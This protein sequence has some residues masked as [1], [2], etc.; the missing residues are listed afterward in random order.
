[1]SMNR[2]EAE[3]TDRNAK[4]TR[5]WRIRVFEPAFTASARCKGA[6]VWGAAVVAR[7]EASPY[8]RSRIEV[9][10]DDLLMTY[11]PSP[12]SGRR[13][14]RSF[15]R[16]WR[17]AS[18]ALSAVVCVLALAL[19]VWAAPASGYRAVAQ[20][21]LAGPVVT[22]AAQLWADK[23]VAWQTGAHTHWLKLS[24][25]VKFTVGVYGFEADNAVVRIVSQVTPGRTIQHMALYLDQARPLPGQTRVAASAPR[26]LVTVSTAGK[27]DLTTN[28]L[29]EAKS[30]PSDELV[31]A[32]EARMARHD[33]A[34][35][36]PL[37]SAPSRP[38]Y[39]KQVQVLRRHRREAIAQSQKRQGIE[40]KSQAA[41]I[42]SRAQ[43]A[44]TGGESAGQGKRPLPPILPVKGAVHFGFDRI[45]VQRDKKQ[46]D[47]M[48]IGHVR[49]IYED[50]QA[51]RSVSLKADK[52]VIFLKG[53]GD[54]GLAG[55]KVKAS[56]V[57][58]VYLED[59]AVAS[60]GQYTLRAPRIYYDVAG[61]RAVLLD[62]VL[63]T[64]DLT[65]R[66]PLYMRANIIRQESATSF[67]AQDAT[68]TNSGFAQPF[69]ALHAGRLSVSQTTDSS[70]KSYQRFSA[71]DTTIRMKGVPLLYFP[72]VSGTNAASPMR[73]VAVG[74]DQH[75]GAQVKT[76]WDIFSLLGIHSPQGTDLTG[77]LDYRGVHGPAIGANLR[78]HRPQFGGRLDSYFLPIDS[79]S[80]HIGGRNDVPHDHQTRGYIRFQH[81][82]QLKQGWQLSLEADQVSDPTF[83]E[84][85]F[86]TQAYDAKP[87]ETSLY[88][89]KQQNDWDLS[90]LA[91]GQLTNFTPQTTTLQAPGY[92]VEQ[93]PDLQYNRTGTPLWDGRLT[94]FSQNS[95]ARVRAYFGSDTP[96]ERGFTQAQSQQL[97]GI[98]ANTSFADAAAARNFPTDWRTRLDTRQEIDAPLR[99]ASLDVTPYVVGRFTAYD[100]GFGDYN[101]ANNRNTRF[102]GEVGTRVHTAWHRTYHVDSK[103]FNLHGIRHI[104][105]PDA[106]FFV[107]G[108]TLKPSDL[109]VYNQNV[110]PLAQGAGMKLGLTNTLQT[111]RGGPGR[112]RN[113]DWITLRTDLILHNH[114]PDIANPYPRFFDYRPEYSVGGNH[115]YTQLLWMVSDTLGVT[116][117]LTDDLETH[118]V[119]QWRV[120]ATI[121]HS[122]N[123]TTFVN[124]EQL[125][126]L[127]SRLLSY[128][129]VYQLTTKYR[130]AISQTIDFEQSSSEVFNFWLERQLPQWKLRFIGSF[131]SI[132]NNTVI[133]V[134]LLPNILAGGPQ[135]SLMSFGPP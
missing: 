82:Q 59:D 15:P 127:N 73:Q 89:K 29:T 65:T 134:I 52:A 96:A 48:L 58:G 115:F 79:G 133:G 108:S 10:A 68:L 55:S 125:R 97:F 70:G 120:G 126:P 25:P 7:A 85:Y 38:L 4:T 80:D 1:M 40:A 112:W 13:F 95:L 35:S 30:P 78:Y 5:L 111:R 31:T 128:G 53:S 20:G 33:A 3:A 87:Y 34:M 64:Y 62:A 56:S 103:L 63:Y 74:Y 81:R 130:A 72:K 57:Q 100:Q 88:L 21:P 102:W 16:S 129:A 9:S 36:R 93:A 106:D 92:S 124:Y 32:A 113:V 17:R 86:E 28:L 14:D 24:G 77:N 23:A 90:L 6:A 94:W 8:I 66:T 101:G 109:P 27:I 91:S 37:L 75:D 114:K 110:E 49:V 71:Q 83:L 61:N 76:K 105:E 41:R 119:V 12:V 60:D 117:E 98:N 116:G 51:H 22:A 132:D 39:G 107:A 54:A 50:Y 43:E 104:I 135:P 26:L 18:A 84:Q 45:V 42:I 131:D 118:Q 69:I 67:S 47:V 2:Q 44:H 19:S 121:D 122:P 46:T 11:L 99:V 123:L